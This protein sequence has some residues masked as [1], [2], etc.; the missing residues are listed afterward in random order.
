MKFPI[1]LKTKWAA[2]NITDFSHFLVIV[3]TEE[4]LIDLFDNN[5]FNFK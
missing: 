4:A 3:Q 2:T 5:K 1:L